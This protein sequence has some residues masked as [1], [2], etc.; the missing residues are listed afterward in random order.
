MEYQPSKI[1]DKTGKSYTVQSAHAE[2]ATELMAFVEQA[3]K[4][5]LYFPWSREGCPK[6]WENTVGYINTFLTA[7][8]YALLLLRDGENIVG[9]IELNGFGDKPEYRHRCTI[10][11][12]LMKTY[13]GR[14]L[15]QALWKIVGELAVSLDYEQVEGSVDSG[16]LPCR[17]AIKKNGWMLFGVLPKYCRH[18]DGSY[19]DKHMY[20]K[21]LTED[22]E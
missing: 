5:S 13:W 6:L 16:N 3:S 22:G 11:P 4:E 20:V 18:P 17:R 9:L 2:D 14:G 8:R 15:V 19:N 7:P 12:G 21:R 1:I 10:A